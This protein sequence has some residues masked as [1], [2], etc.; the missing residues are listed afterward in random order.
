MGSFKPT[1]YLTTEE[2]QQLASA[3]FEEAAT[4]PDGPERE[5]V[6]KEFVAAND[7]A[8]FEHAR[9]FF[10]AY[11]GE[12]FIDGRDAELWKGERFVAK[13]KSDWTGH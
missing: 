12:L 7:D 6:L 1:T 9:Q 3:K 11:D 4:L 10:D 8:A 2:L 5:Q 13:L